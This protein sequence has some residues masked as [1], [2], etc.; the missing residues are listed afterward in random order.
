MYFSGAA[1]G[2]KAL[3]TLVQQYERSSCSMVT[4]WL[5]GRMEDLCTLDQPQTVCFVISVWSL[6]SGSSGLVAQ[7][8]HGLSYMFLWLESGT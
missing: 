1:V 3:V 7:A 2:D 4:D 6:S 8:A 5:K